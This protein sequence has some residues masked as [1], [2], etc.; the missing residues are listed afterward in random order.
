[1]VVILIILILYHHKSNNTIVVWRVWGNRSNPYGEQFADR[2]IINA[3]H[4]TH[5][6]YYLGMYLTLYS[7]VH[8]E[9]DLQEYASQ[10]R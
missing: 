7:H 4:Q 5:P 9:R 8:V 3:T 1:M 6:F 2:K 10:H